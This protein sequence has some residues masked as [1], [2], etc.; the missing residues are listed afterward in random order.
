M[1]TTRRGALGG[2]V[3]TLALAACGGGDTGQGSTPSPTPTPTPTPTPPP[4]A[5]VGIL[6]LGMSVF[7]G[8]DLVGGNYPDRAAFSADHTPSRYFAKALTAARRPIDGLVREYNAAVG[9]SFDNDT[10]SQYAGAPGKPYD[11]VLLGLAMNSGSTYGVN[12]RGP[13][14]AFT[15]EVL[16]PLLRDIQ[17][18]G[19]VP[20]VCNTV[21]PWPEKI[22]PASITSALQDGIAWPPDQ[23]TLLFSGAL[24]FDSANNRF[25]ALSV[26]AD[27]RGIFDR[28]GG[29]RKIK[30]GSKLYIQDGGG[31]N[32]GIVLTVTARISGTTVEVEAGV[33]SDD[34]VIS[35][36]V[37][38]F[39]PPIDEF[40]VPPSTQQLQHKDWTG[41]GI[42]VDGLASYATWNGILI[43]LCREEN[44][45]IVDLEYRGFKWVE[46]YGWPSVYTSNYDGVPFETFNHPQLAAQSVIYGEMMSWL[47]NAVNA[48]TLGTGFQL[49]RGPTIA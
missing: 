36:T 20:F 2:I 45:K 49:L 25:G 24:V 7:L 42:A 48:G 46:R 13:N 37:R 3:S 23:E 34:G 4:K 33:I 21:H 14:A 18:A 19:A 38:H 12:G 1:N 43:D 44:V 27:G 11:I 8:A 47:A 29:G 40:L 6:T 17:A 5:A 30:P 16:R 35:G 32:A 9:G 22:T 39:D 10:P 28:A 15:K 41:S 31:T 26:D